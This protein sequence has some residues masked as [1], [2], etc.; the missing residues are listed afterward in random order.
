MLHELFVLLPAE[1]VA[2]PSPVCARV[3]V[4]VCVC[5]H[6]CARVRVAEVV[7]GSILPN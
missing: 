1:S 7:T 2:L 3:C 5:R 4:C 6:A